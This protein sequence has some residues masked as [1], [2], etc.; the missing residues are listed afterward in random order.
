[1]QKCIAGKTPQQHCVGYRDS[2]IGRFC[3]KSSTGS[4]FINS[5]AKWRH[6]PGTLNA[7]DLVSR[8]CSGEH[9]LQGKWWEGPTWLLENEENLPKSEDEPDEDLVN[10]EK[11]KTIATTLTKTDENVNWYRILSKDRV[12]DAATFETA[13]LAAPLYLKKGPKAYIVLYTCAVYWAIH[14]EL[15]PSLTTK[16]FFQSLRRFIS[17]RG[18]PLPPYIL[19]TARILSEQRDFCMLWISIASL[20]ELPKKKFSASLILHLH[21]G[22]AD[23][24]ATTTQV[25]IPNRIYLG[26][27]RQQSI[28]NYKDKPLS[29]L[30]EDNSKKRAYWSLA[31][32]L[33]LIP[34]REGHIRH[35]LIKT[36]HSEFLRPVQRL[37]RLELDNSV[38]KVTEDVIRVCSTRIV[39]TP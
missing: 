6:I 30:L 31:R 15:I 28:K 3:S 37:F 12:R 17:H 19:T 39:K 27:F 20:P 18:R 14:L 38:G 21:S 13:G 35:A 26:K 25:E 9:L 23:E 5:P 33:K 10:S 4:T 32:V 22:G 2:K 29:V 11:R 24:N 7:A 8:G 34:G 1:M 36:E 16:A